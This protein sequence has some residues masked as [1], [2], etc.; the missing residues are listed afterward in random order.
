[1]QDFHRLKDLVIEIPNFPKAGILFK[2]ISPLLKTH[3]NETI[4][5]MSILF[6]TPEWQTFDLI[7]GIESR[8]FIFAS[9]LAY[10]HK[11]GFVKIRKPGKLPR[12]FGNIHYGLEYGE[13][14]LEM[15]R[16][17]GSKLLIVDDILATGGSLE[18]AANLAVNVGYKVVGMMCLINLC[19]LNQFKWQGMTCRTVMSFD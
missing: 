1:M 8:G 5:A 2:D 14:S 3:F 19:Q 7:A 6:S 12:V 4:E 15:Q 16:G 10:K 9:A 13:S 18:A 17:D 11:K